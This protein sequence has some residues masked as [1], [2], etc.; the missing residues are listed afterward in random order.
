MIDLPPILTEPGDPET[1]AAIAEDTESMLRAAGRFV[2]D[3]TGK[4]R[5]CTARA[6]RRA[7]ACQGDAPLHQGFAC[8]RPGRQETA[9]ICDLVV[10]T[11][12]DR[13]RRAGGDRL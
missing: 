4:W 6:C 1:E 10:F 12:L 7:K 3:R 9:R 5:T 13:V 8:G 11:L 2:A